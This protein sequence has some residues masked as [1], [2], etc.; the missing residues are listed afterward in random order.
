M[1]RLINRFDGEQGVLSSVQR[2]TDGM[3][4]VATSARESGPAMA[5]TMRDLREAAD[6][7]RQ[8]ADSLEL[9][10]DMLLKGRARAAGVVKP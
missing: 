5:A 7:V 10:P 3:G 8:L 4:D 1:Q 2:A 9:D 6:S